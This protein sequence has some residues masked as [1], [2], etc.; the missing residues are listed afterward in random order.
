[1]CVDVYIISFSFLFWVSDNSF[2][3]LSSFLEQSYFHSLHHS[4]SYTE[5]NL[6]YCSIF[7]IQCTQQLTIIFIPIKFCIYDPMCVCVCDRVY[8]MYFW[9][10]IQWEH[11]EWTLGWIE[12]AKKI[13]HI[14][15]LCDCVQ[16]ERICIMHVQVEYF[17]II[18]LRNLCFWFSFSKLYIFDIFSHFRWFNQQLHFN[19]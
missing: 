7:G 19:F 11:I 14:Q 18:H 3:A 5:K 17:P 4:E 13:L 15:N 2:D 6:L 9:S 1:M 12:N 8:N 10:S 16:E